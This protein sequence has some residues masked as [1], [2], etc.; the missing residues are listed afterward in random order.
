M[1]SA[2]K[3]MIEFDYKIVCKSCV[4]I[5]KHSEIFTHMKDELMTPTQIE[6]KIKHCLGNIMGHAERGA[7]IS[8][9]YH[10]G[11]L[12]LRFEVTNIR[13]SVLH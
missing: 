5:G 1:S 6:Y 10:Q 8:T 4:L 7:L 13:T 3:L 11:M 2:R 9:P 12:N